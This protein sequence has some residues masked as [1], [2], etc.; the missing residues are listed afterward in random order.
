MS[1][2]HSHKNHSHLAGKHKAWAIVTGGNR[3]LGFEACRQLAKE[4]VPVILTARNVV[5]G[6]E[7][8]ETL[9]KEG[10]EVVFRA[11]DVSRSESIDH[12][13]RELKSEGLA[14]DVL[15]NNAG[16]MMDHEADQATHSGDFRKPLR[17]T[18]EINVYG[19]LEL[20]LKLAPLMKDGSRIINLSSGMGQL[21]DMGG[22]WHSYRISKAAI[23]AVTRILAAE[24]KE[25][26]I[27]VNSVSPGWA[28]TDMGGEGAPLT[29]E[30]GVQTIVWLATQ[31]QDGPT[32]Q[33]FD[34]DQDPMAW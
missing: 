22:G 20:S 30:Q 26:R 18:M 19:A 9:C 12:F 25:R 27:H 23:N 31:K 16:I 14:I 1:Q 7:A 10:Y 34:E 15:V 5:H 4:G 11:L 24:L 32:G 21:S 2:Q 17:E 8:A 28:R 29:P 6:R 33:F 13:V 3:G